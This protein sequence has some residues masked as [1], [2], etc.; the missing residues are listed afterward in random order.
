MVHNDHTN[1]LFWRVDNQTLIGRFYLMHMIAIRPELRDFIIG[2]SCDY[3]FIPEMCPSNNVE[4]VADSDDYLVIELQPQK[5][6]SRNCS[7]QALRSPASLPAAL[8][9][10]TTARHRENSATTVVFHADEIPASIGD[11]VAEADRFMADVECED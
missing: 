6:R 2:S 9:E 4:I 1:R 8:S 7:N 10:W 11:A 5:S 3:S